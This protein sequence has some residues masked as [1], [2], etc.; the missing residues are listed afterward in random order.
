MN[1]TSFG[2]GPH[3]CRRIIFEGRVQ[4]V[5]F[6]YTTASAAR[7]Y[8]INGYVRNCPDGSVELVASGHRQQVEQLLESLVKNFAGHIERQSVEELDVSEPF[9]GFEIRR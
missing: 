1:D 3:C 7:A 2:P 8:R 5:G 4:G 9:D 6:R